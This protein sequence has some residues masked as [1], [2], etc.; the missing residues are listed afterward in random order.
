MLTDSSSLEDVML[1]IE[2]EYFYDVA[3]KHI[4]EAIYELVMLEGKEAD[5]IT[6]KTKLEEKKLL[7]KV[8]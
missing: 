2:P 7:E 5:L 4:V 8:G 1:D 3:N 6:L